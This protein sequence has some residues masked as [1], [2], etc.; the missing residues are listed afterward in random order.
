MFSGSGEK[1]LSPSSRTTLPEA[2][3]ELKRHGQDAIKI[4]YAGG[5]LRR[6]LQLGRE[7]R[8]PTSAC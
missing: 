3:E 4:G 2:I 7:S 1:S 5:H 6:F 8:S